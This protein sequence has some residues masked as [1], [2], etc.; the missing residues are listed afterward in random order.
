MTAEDEKAA[1]LAAA[2]RANLAKRKAQKRARADGGAPG[3][4]RS[5]DAPGLHGAM[6]S[7]RAEGSGEKE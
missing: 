3:D 2:L 5:D 7:G 1:R 6:P 4:S